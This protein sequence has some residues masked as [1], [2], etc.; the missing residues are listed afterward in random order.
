[1]D[2]ASA[3]SFAEPR[4]FSSRRSCS[5]SS[6][7]DARPTQSHSVARSSAMPSRANIAAWR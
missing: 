7:H 6:H 5:G 3:N 1:M 2:V 4:K